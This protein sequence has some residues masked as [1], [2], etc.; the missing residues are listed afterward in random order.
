[1][2]SDLPFNREGYDAARNV[3]AI[4][5]LV[6]VGFAVKLFFFPHHP[7]KQKCAIHWIFLV[8]TW[9][10]IFQ[11]RNFTTCP[12]FTPTRLSRYR[13]RPR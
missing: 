10:R 8:C 4:F 12:S 1:M 6:L 9:V 13:Y 11:C 2:L 7:L 5:A 3:T